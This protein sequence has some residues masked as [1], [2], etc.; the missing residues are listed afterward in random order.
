MSWSRPGTL[1]GATV[2]VSVSERLTDG[3]RVRSVLPPRTFS[4][5]EINFLFYYN[6]LSRPQSSI[7]LSASR[8]SLSLSCRLALGQ[9]PRGDIHLLVLGPNLLPLLLSLSSVP[10]MAP[11][12]LLRGAAFV[13]LSIHLCIHH[14]SFSFSLSSRLSTGKVSG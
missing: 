3:L 8:V 2:R 5:V 9:T 7:P 1:C 12:G 4:F 11:R 10:H 6:S 13:H 14:H